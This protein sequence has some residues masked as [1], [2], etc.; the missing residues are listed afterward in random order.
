MRLFLERADGVIDTSKMFAFVPSLVDA[1]VTGGVEIGI[2]SS[3]RRKR[4][5]HVL[6]REGI[7]KHF[8][9]IIGFEDV[10]ELKPDPTGLL[11]AVDALGAPKERCLYVGD[12]ITDAETARRAEVTFVAVLSGTTEQIAFAEYGPAMVLRDASELSDYM[13]FG[14]D[15]FAR[16]KTLSDDH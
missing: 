5:S 11:R 15:G 8:K 1:L 7:D 14:A 2:V 9:V 13:A 16:G 4:I 3:A 12:S 10:K 6:R